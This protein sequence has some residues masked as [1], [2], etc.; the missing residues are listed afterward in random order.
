MAEAAIIRRP[1]WRA[2]LDAYLDSIWR[3]TFDWREMNCLHFG[4]G[5]IEAETGVV[6]GGDFSADD[7]AACIDA[8]SAVRIMLRKGFS[9]HGDYFAGKLREA[10]PSE[11]RHGD[12]AMVDIGFGA[13]ALVNPLELICLTPDGLAVLPRSAATRAFI[14]DFAS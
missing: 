10:H 5:V 8:K 4:G 9:S 12:L 3:R 11:A 7:R 2:R 1:D 14:I 6:L 13:M